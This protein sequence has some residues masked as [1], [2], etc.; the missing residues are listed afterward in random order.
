[1]ER[2]AEALRVALPLSL[3]DQRF[4]DPANREALGRSLATLSEAASS[5]QS[6]GLDRDP[7]FAFLSR[8]STVTGAI[9]GGPEQTTIYV[10]YGFEF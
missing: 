4:A 9:V 3:N 8:A 6:H 1:M 7:S 2:I 10:G 5:L